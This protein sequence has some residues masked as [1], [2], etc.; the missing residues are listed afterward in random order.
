[1]NC[2]MSKS[3]T[4]PR[5]Q[6]WFLLARKLLYLIAITDI[7]FVLLSH[8]SPI[9]FAYDF[10]KAIVFKYLDPRS[11]SAVGVYLSHPYRRL[12]TMSNLQSLILTRKLMLLHYTGCSLVIAAEAILSL[13]LI[14][15]LQ[16]LSRHIISCF[17]FFTSTTIPPYNML[18]W[19]LYLNNCRH[20]ILCLIICQFSFHTILKCALILWKDHPDLILFPP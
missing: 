9:P 18:F 7:S 6:K 3:S 19:S 14:S 8:P 1:M 15:L 20:I 13:A 5:W 17:D 4:S 2:Y 11:V 12:D 10:P 16:L